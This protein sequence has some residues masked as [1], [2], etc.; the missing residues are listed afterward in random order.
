MLQRLVQ[1][2]LAAS[3]DFPIQLLT[4][5][6]GTRDWDAA[7][8]NAVGDQV[9][10]TSFHDGYFNE[11]SGPDFSEGAVTTC[12]MRPR[13]QLIQAVYG[14]REELN[15]T[16][17]TIAISLDEWGLGPPW[18]VTNFGVAHGMYAAGFLSA[19][20]RSAQALNIRFTNYFE[21]V[22]EGAVQVG[23]F[24]ATLTPVGQVM[25]LYGQHQG[26]QRVMLP[27]VSFSGPLDTLVTVGEGSLLV[28]MANL[29]AVGWATCSVSITLLGWDVTSSDIAT[30]TLKAQGFSRS[31]LFD[32]EPDSTSVKGNAVHV[33]VP[34]LSVVHF[35]I[36]GR[37]H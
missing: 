26:R 36:A 37:V 7:W 15:S 10:A 14:L 29:N 33:D 3:P 20:T 9:F 13:D 18:R 25:E 23:P 16:N 30:T 2:M 28:T 22:N 8:A 19:V 21:P 12:T 35:S 34:P 1:P 17:K 5:S 32:I 11:P 31:S 4:V 24:S 6:G 27:N